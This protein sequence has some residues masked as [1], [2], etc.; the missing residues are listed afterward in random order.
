MERGKEKKI[1]RITAETQVIRCECF[2]YSFLKNG[3]CLSLTLVYFVSVKGRKTGRHTYTHSLSHTSIKRE[4]VILFDI[5][6]VVVVGIICSYTLFLLLN[7][8]AW[9]WW[10]CMFIRGKK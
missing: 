6:A 5:I 3:S 10:W 8:S 9:C 7:F 4:R 2:L 1:K